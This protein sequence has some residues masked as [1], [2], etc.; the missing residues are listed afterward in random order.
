M[1][2]T[3]KLYRKTLQRRMCGGY[4]QDTKGVWWLWNSQRGWVKANTEGAAFRECM[5][6]TTK[7]SNI[8]GRLFQGDI[9]EAERIIVRAAAR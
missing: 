3:F 7:A 5:E 1:P 8:L 9:F 6:Y 2:K 4:Y